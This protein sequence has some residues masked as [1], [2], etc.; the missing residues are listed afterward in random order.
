[1]VVLTW[2]NPTLKDCP[3]KSRRNGH[4]I[5]RLQLRFHFDST[6]FDSHSTTIRR[7]TAV[8]SKC[9][10]SR[11]RGCNH[12]PTIGVTTQRVSACVR[13]SR[14][15]QRH[16]NCRPP[17]TATYSVFSTSF[18]LSRAINCLLFGDDIQLSIL[19]TLFLCF[20]PSYLFMCWSVHVLPWV[21]NQT[22]LSRDNCLK[23]W[24]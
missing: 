3:C 11:S 21:T 24:I 20:F 14:S 4:L 7:R 1:M 6:P 23:Q 12:R 22:N 18:I 2:Q 9:N 10:P 16:C 15:W 17:R 5:R 13:V 19:Y 8:Q